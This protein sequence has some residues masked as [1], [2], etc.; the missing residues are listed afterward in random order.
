MPMTIYTV[1]DR[2]HGKRIDTIYRPEF[3]SDSRV[4]VSISEF[5]F[6]GGVVKRFV[7]DAR[8]TVHNV[9]CAEGVLTVWS[10]IEW[11]YDLPYSL[12]ILII[13]LF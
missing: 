3:H 9:A 7:G 6:D 5:S 10:E 4:F 2:G 12:S 8:T 1:E 11:G 13:N